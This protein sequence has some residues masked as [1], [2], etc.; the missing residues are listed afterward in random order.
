MP[1]LTPGPQPLPMSWKAAILSARAARLNALVSAAN[2]ENAHALR[3][4]LTQPNGEEQFNR[5][6]FHCELEEGQIQALLER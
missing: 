5:L 6:I 3:N 1:V 4:G 2:A